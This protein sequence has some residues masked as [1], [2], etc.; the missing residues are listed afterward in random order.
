MTVRAVRYLRVST[1]A[2]SQSDRFG[3]ARQVDICERS[4]SRHALEAVTTVTDTIS[5]GTRE[6]PGLDSLAQAARRHGAT[7]I[8]LS[9]VDRLSRDITGGHI[10]IDALVS[11][12]LDIYADDL[13]ARVN[14]RDI[15]SV[16]EINDRLRQAHEERARIR[17]RTYGGLLAKARGTRNQAA[18]P[19]RVLNGYGFQDGRVH[20]PQARWV[21]FIFDR[22]QEVGSVTILNELNERGV[23]PPSGSGLWSKGAV[24]RILNHP[25]HKGEYIYGRE[26][27]C[28]NATCGEVRHGSSN[29]AFRGSMRC[30][31]CGAPMTLNQVRI[32][33]PSIVEPAEW[34]AAQQ[35]MRT[36]RRRPGRRGSRLATFSLQGRARCGVC[37]GAMSAQAMT[38]NPA[39]KYYYCRR[40]IS[41]PEVDGRSW[42]CEHRKMY[43]IEPLH[44]AV[45]DRIASAFADDDSVH[46]AVEGSLVDVHAAER[47]AADRERR[48]V[49]SRLER[50]D[51]AYEAGVMPLERYAVRRRELEGALTLVPD[52]PPPP[53][54][55]TDLDE[56]IATV[57]EALVSRPLHEV[58]DV[59]RV[60]VVVHPGMEFAVVLRP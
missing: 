28:T 33:V 52:F 2:Q 40:A 32:D 5:G 23:P 1:V 37:G 54:I 35:A 25:I 51:E 48:E 3:F 39:L 17:D 8:S 47:D 53:T 16:R 6:R 56:Y 9:E 20:E 15:E 59:G 50:L 44:E 10:I 19:P 36:R 46:L 22:I 11:T 27:R 41:R 24:L 49:R 60:T 7:A 31:R 21:R 4:E 45:R 13:R 26:G 29:E 58:L 38:K 14:L 34:D 12:G 18:E 42:R 55:R 43:R 57:R 30:T